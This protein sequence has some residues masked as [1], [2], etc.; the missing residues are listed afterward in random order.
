MSSVASH[1]FVREQT[2]NIFHMKVLQEIAVDLINKTF[3]L[4]EGEKGEQKETERES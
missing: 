4:P 3:T 1:L 2:S